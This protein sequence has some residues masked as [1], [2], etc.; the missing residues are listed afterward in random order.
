MITAKRKK[1]ILKY[2]ENMI[3]TNPKNKHILQVNTK[4]KV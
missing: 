4:E 1:K 3:F 2:S